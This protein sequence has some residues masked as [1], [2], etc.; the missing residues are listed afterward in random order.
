MPIKR[1]HRQVMQGFDRFR[2][3]RLK[4]ATW[5]FVIFP[6]TIRK[7]TEPAKTKKVSEGLNN[8]TESSSS[9]RNL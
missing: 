3:N 2:L 8:D 5:Y 4:L 9:V 7:K 6:G 1:Q